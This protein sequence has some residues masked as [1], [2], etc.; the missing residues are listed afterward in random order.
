MASFESPPFSTNPNAPKITYDVYFQEKAN[1][2]GILIASILYGARSPACASPI[3]VLTSSVWLILGI[4][5][6]LFFQCVAALFN[7]AHR[8]GK[9]SKWGLLSYITATF[10]VVTVLIAMQ[11]NLQSI[12]YI[13]NREYPGVDGVTPPGPLGYQE[14]IHASA[15][16]VIPD[17]MFLLNGWMADALLVSSLFD[18]AISRLEV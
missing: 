16:T 12:S 10:S 11:L 3:C 6:V 15:L 5:I 7:S 8:R 14:S 17:L 2:A 9:N 1:F 13:D 4:V 18:A